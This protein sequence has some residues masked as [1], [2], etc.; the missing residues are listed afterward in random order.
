MDAPVM[1]E[2]MI[3][4]WTISGSEGVERRFAKA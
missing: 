2:P 1:P 4:V 3:T